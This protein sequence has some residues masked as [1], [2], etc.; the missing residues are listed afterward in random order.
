MVFSNNINVSSYS[1]SSAIEYITSLHQQ[2]IELISNGHF[3][4]A[5]QAMD[6]IR[7]LRSLFL[8]H[9]GNAIDSLREST[10]YDDMLSLHSVVAANAEVASTLQE[11]RK[12]FADYGASL[13][14]S[15]DRDEISLG[16]DISLPEIWN[17]NNDVILIAGDNAEHV[18]S[19]LQE[20]GQKNVIQ[21][22]EAINEDEALRQVS[23]F[24][25][26]QVL[27][28]S[29][30]GS[31]AHQAT[32]QKVYDALIKNISQ[33]NTIEKYTPIVVRQHIQ[34]LTNLQKF[35]NVNIADALRPEISGKNVIVVSPG[36]SLKKNIEFLRDLPPETILLAPAQSFQA[37]AKHQINPD[38]IVIIDHSDYSDVLKSIDPNKVKGL[39]AAETCHPSF[40]EF[41][42]NSVFIIPHIE[43]PQILGNALGS[44]WRPA[45]YGASVSV[46][47]V[48]LSCEFN[49]SAVAVVGQ[50]LAVDQGTYYNRSDRMIQEAQSHLGKRIPIKGYY[51]GTAYTRS[52]YYLYLRELEFLASTYSE[53]CQLVNCTE[54]GAFI[55]GWQ[56]EPL[57]TFLRLDAMSN[58]AE[59]LTSDINETG[60]D[61]KTEV[62]RA[63]KINIE[64]GQKILKRVNETIRL[65]NEVES[66]P[67][68]MGKLE[69]AEAQL[70]ADVAS[71]AWLNSLTRNDLLKLK[72]DISE[73]ISLSENLDLSS[74]YYRAVKE[75]TIGLLTSLQKKGQ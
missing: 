74:R 68:K 26:P 17:F 61:W 32:L 20:R 12:Q 40:L 54:G 13:L 30:R 58:N 8:A 18:I 55:D 62:D 34:N 59:Q 56:H 44:Q 6:R 73:V 43:M 10:Q 41:D 9:Y 16:L 75:Q 27:I 72:R 28:L 53:K 67:T 71:L 45:E 33:F 64:Q 49:A 24:T 19:C 14:E 36:P 50:D 35:K 39:I 15:E 65:I 66:K 21:I 3:D 63:I 57:V 11:W 51:G 47:A 5:R 25:Q 29:C 48:A 70:N 46:Q 2:A 60:V 52:D 38:Y 69:K 37:L 1:L 7:V 42:W 4:K 31:A 23:F 22:F